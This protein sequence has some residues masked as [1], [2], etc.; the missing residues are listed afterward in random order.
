MREKP[1]KHPESWREMRRL[2]AWELKRKGW[3]QKAIA[4]A[5]GVSEGAVSQWVKR[6]EAGGRALWLS[7]G[8][9]DASSG[10]HAHRARV[11]GSILDGACRALALC[12]RPQ[13]R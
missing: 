11:R 7:G 8:H 1:V 5:L 13:S 6:A 9:L 10:R 4:E 2:R 12:P 3:K